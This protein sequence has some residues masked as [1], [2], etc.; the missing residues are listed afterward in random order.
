[1][2]FIVDN[3]VFS[4]AFNT[5]AFDVFED[6]WLPWSDLMEKGTIV[7][8]DEVYCE[9]LVRWSEKSEEGK[10]L[11]NHKDSFHKP[12]NDEGYIVSDIFKNRKFRESIKE[13]SLRNGS[14]EADAFIIAK[15]KVENGIVVTSESDKKPNSEKIPNI[16]IAFDVPYMNMD[17]FFRML[18]N[19][20]NGRE[21]FDG[22]CICQKLALPVLLSEVI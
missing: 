10:W 22:V 4:R 13:S 9:L 14:P 8:V 15:A 6:I 12:S 3:N 7:S 5:M 19:I 11:K 18:K 21:V 1:M 20:Y 16:A 2:I 17:E